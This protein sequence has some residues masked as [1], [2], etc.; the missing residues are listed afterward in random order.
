MDWEP[1]ELGWLLSHR[2]DVFLRLE[3]YS[4]S[5]RKG[6][7]LGLTPT[8]RDSIR[9]S[10]QL[11]HNSR[12]NFLT[13]RLQSLTFLSPSMMLFHLPQLMVSTPVKNWTNFSFKKLILNHMDANCFLNPNLSCFSFIRFCGGNQRLLWNRESRANNT[14]VQS[15][16]DRNLQQCDSVCVLGQCSSFWGC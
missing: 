12:S 6:V 16:V 10:N 15:K 7:F 8:P 13:L 9:R 11:Q 14:V 1:G 3:L 4:D 2:W 5:T